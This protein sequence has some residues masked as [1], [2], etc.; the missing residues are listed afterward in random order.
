M[1]IKTFEIDP[2]SMRHRITLLR[3][4][5]TEAALWPNNAA[6]EA[7]ATIWAA[8]MD[9]SAREGV[10]AE[11]L[12][13]SESLRFVIRHRRDIDDVTALEHD[14]AFYDLHSIHDPDQRKSWLIL[15]SRKAVGDGQ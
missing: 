1:S 15:T 9:A 8:I 13:N 5:A 6:N 10:I 4:N 3:R 12:H 11:Q 2:S 14:G 7:V